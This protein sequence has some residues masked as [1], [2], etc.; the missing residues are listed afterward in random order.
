MSLIFEFN[1]ETFSMTERLR[2]SVVMLIWSPEGVKTFYRRSS[3]G[4]F[5]GLV[6]WGTWFGF[7]WT[8]FW[9]DWYDLARIIFLTLFL[10]L[11]MF[12]FRLSKRR[13][14]IKFIVSRKRFDL[15]FRSRGLS[16]ANDGERLTSIN[17]GFMSLSRRISKP[18]SSKQLF[19]CGIFFKPAVIWL[20][21]DM[22]LLRMTSYILDQTRLT[23][24]PN[25]SKYLFMAHKLHLC[26]WSSW[27]AC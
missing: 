10:I 11:F 6:I 19:L 20:S 16:V 1:W 4:K 14:H 21:T 23:S 17:H 24:I 15:I 2:S 8:E 7:V 5:K 12:S 22:R 27:S 18:R 25:F 9:R 13:K 3:P 26:P